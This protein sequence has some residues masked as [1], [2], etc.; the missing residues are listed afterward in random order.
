[1]RSPNPDHICGLCDEFDVDQA[2]PGCAAKGEARC[3]ARTEASML[4]L[5]VPWDGWP[6]VSF[7]LDWPNIR[8]KRQFI[9]VQ[10]RAQAPA[11]AEE[12]TENMAG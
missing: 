2:A 11:H 10:R 4:N 5:H 1:M 12:V 3:L 9:T 8:R 6:C 7:R